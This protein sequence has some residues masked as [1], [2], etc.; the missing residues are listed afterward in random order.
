VS[1]GDGFVPDD[2][3]EDVLRRLAAVQTAH[4]FLI[5]YVLKQLFCDYDPEDRTRIAAHLI[6]RSKETEHF[7]AITTDDRLADRFAD[8]VVRSQ[9][10]IETM[11][12]A[13]KKAADGRRASSY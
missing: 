9:E 13:A 5:D 12:Q 2:E 7:A 6:E 1:G 8:I 10:K 3:L 4:E 11:V